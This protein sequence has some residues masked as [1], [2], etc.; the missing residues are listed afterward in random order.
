MK[1]LISLFIAQLSLIVLLFVNTQNVLASPV[2]TN[3]YLQQTTGIEDFTPQAILP[4]SYVLGSAD[5]PSKISLNKIYTTASQSELPNIVFI[6]VDD[7]PPGLLGVAGNNII[8]TPNIDNLANSGVYLTNMYVPLGICAPSRA[9]I[10]T[11]KYPHTNGLT[12]N[13]LILPPDQITLPEILKANGYN[14]GIVGKCHLGDPRDSEKYKRGFDYRLI[15]YPDW[16]GLNDWY[17]YQFNRNGTIETHTNKYVSDFLTDESIQFIQNNAN[18]GKPFFLWLGHFAPHRPTTPPLGQ[19][20]YDKNLLPLPVS[21]SDDLSAKPP[22]QQ[23]STIH[24]I[25]QDL[26]L[27]G[28][29]QEL[30]DAYEVMTNLDG[31]VGR[32]VKTLDD[33]GIKNNTIIIYMSDNGLFYGEHQLERKGPTFYNE[34]MKTPFIISYP[35]LNLPKNRSNAMV[36]SVDILP[37][38]LDL[39]KIPIPGDV[40]GKSFLNIL[41]GTVNSIRSSVFFEF[42]ENQSAVYPNITWDPYPMRGIVHNG[43]KWA[44][45]LAS[46]ARGVSYDGQNFELYNLNNDP[47]EVNNLMKRLGPD[48]NPL[49]RTLI[50]PTYG[51]DVLE[52]LKEM[53]IWQT[54]TLD[55]LRRIISNFNYTTSPSQVTLNW[56]TD[57]TTTTI[58]DYKEK[59][60]STCSQNHLNNFN[61]STDHNVTLTGLK[62]G[63]TYE[64]S[65]YSFGPF[66]SG[67]YKS[68]EIKTVLSGNLNGDGKVDILDYNLMIQNFGKSYTIFDYNNLVTNYGK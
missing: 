60:C 61:I 62:T 19:N 22:Q 8:K 57:L 59:D 66:G 18:K 31:N 15:G 63:K 1:R 43:Y 64:I 41:N 10:W 24:R 13:G 27:G 55:P 21:I 2:L 53:A 67:V 49:M 11:G 46:T 39:L 33:L 26:G 38:I 20:I 28:V 54:D 37:T 32:V 65:A 52:L 23:N 68:L 4:D 9:S 6:I 25:F 48:D 50:N 42:S 29:R 51:N 40:Q 14:T 36:E 45:Y 7:Q 16:G 47:N 17:N 12:K 30:D 34:Q 35:K 44:H 56:N 3:E 5:A 58:V